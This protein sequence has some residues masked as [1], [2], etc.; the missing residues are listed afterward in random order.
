[1]VGLLLRMAHADHG[2]DG[3]QHNAQYQR[4]GCYQQRG[5]HALKILLP[6]VRIQKRLVEF[7]KEILSK[8]QLIAV[9]CHF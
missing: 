3:A 4:N 1:M 9:F 5:T 7:H 8:V 2:H 6:A